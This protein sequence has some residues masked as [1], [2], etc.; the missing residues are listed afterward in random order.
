MCVSKLPSE[1]SPIGVLF[2]QNIYAVEYNNL[3]MDLNYEIYDSL[4]Q[5][6]DSMNL[7]AVGDM[8]W[9]C[10]AKRHLEIKAQDMIEL[11]L[12]GIH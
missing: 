1:I 10:F 11:F 4:P 12:S 8:I 7:L 3:G 2:M 6:N 9:F 5:K